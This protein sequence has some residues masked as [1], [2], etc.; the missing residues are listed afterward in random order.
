ML[1]ERVKWG[2]SIRIVRHGFLLMLLLWGTLEVGY[3]Q[4]VYADDQRSGT[5]SGLGSAV[6]ENPTFS[7]N[8]NY[9]DFTILK[10]NGAL[11][12]PTAWQQLIFP[13]AIPANSVVY[14][15]ITSTTAL[16]GGGITAQAYT[17]SDANN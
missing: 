3:G 14:I 7:I 1:G 15:K 5:T 13:A 10:T 16:L 2:N 4:R 11:I 9:S 12:Q 8:S 6:V 17:N